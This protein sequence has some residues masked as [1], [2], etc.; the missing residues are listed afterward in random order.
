[1]II[2]FV[3]KTYIC[4]YDRQKFSVTG[5]PSDTRTPTTAPAKV[6][7]LKPPL[8]RSIM[9]SLLTTVETFF[10][11]YSAALWVPSIVTS[12]SSVGLSVRL[13]HEEQV[14]LRW[15]RDRATAYQ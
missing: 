14:A 9:N 13:T 2:G 3:S 12:V 7:V 10:H 8:D 11:L 1:M 4:T 6:E 5:P 15:Q